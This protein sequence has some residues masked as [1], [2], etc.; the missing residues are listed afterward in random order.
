MAS[1]SYGL[2]G[3]LPPGTTGNGLH[4]VWIELMTV[5]P[6]PL[7]IYSGLLGVGIG[8]RNKTNRV[9]TLQHGMNN[10]TTNTTTD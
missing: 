8:P 1:L 2:S 9:I 6:I 7:E 3:P 4:Q 5:D 10:V